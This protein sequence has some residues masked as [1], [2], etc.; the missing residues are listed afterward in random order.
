ML[1]INVLIGENGKIS[2]DRLASSQVVAHGINRARI[3]FTSNKLRRK[4]Q[5]WVRSNQV[6]MF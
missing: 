6:L 3:G 5:E 4:N 1:L 2:T